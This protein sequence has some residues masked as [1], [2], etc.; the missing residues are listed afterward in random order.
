ML[1]GVCNIVNYNFRMLKAPQTYD[2]LRLVTVQF[3]K[4]NIA[5]RATGWQPVSL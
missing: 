1:G 2:S 5:F 4:F 3:R